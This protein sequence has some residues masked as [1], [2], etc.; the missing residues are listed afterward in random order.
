MIERRHALIQIYG[1]YHG[2]HTIAMPAHIFSY[3]KE[4]K[5][6]H[7]ISGRPRDRAYL[8]TATCPQ[9]CMSWNFLWEL[10]DLEEEEEESEGASPSLWL[11]AL[12]EDRIV[13]N[14]NSSNFDASPLWV[15]H[16][17]KTTSLTTIDLCVLLF[18]LTSWVKR[19][20]WPSWTIA[21]K[22]S[23]LPSFPLLVK[24]SMIGSNAQSWGARCSPSWSTT[25]VYSTWR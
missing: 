11:E 21:S 16:C 4:I 22:H 25:H 19:S 5:K 23:N 24:R 14:W 12:W 2:L 17:N 6:Q 7:R 3:A 20:A 8:H 18:I 15:H 13:N 1:G 10:P 9:L